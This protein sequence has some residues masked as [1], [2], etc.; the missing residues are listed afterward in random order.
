MV[1]LLPMEK[2]LTSFGRMMRLRMDVSPYFG[3]EYECACGARHKLDYHIELLCQGY[4]K[5][6]AVCPD[7]PDYLTTVK[8]HMLLMVKFLRLKGVNGTRIDAEDDY[9]LLCGVFRSLK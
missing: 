4:W 9:Q 2:F 6:I 8:I 1:P 7:D 5:V 3:H